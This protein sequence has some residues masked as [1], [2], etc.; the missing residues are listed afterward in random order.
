MFLPPIRE[1][2]YSH[3]SEPASQS[4]VKTRV[5]FLRI[6]VIAARYCRLANLEDPRLFR[7]PNERFLRRNVRF[8]KTISEV[9]LFLI[10]ITF[11]F[12]F[13]HKPLQLGA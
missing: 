10:I 1:I 4:I 3:T 5:Y 7:L 6:H 11:I 2:V 9:Y 13:T 12:K 8:L